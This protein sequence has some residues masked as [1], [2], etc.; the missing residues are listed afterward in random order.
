M[1]SLRN[2]RAAPPSYGSFF[3]RLISPYASVAI[4][5]RDQAAAAAAAADVAASRKQNSRH[6]CETHALGKIALAPKR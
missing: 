6:M 5:A 1:L 3:M 4:G 2:A